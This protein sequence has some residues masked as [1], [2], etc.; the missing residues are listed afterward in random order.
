[1]VGSASKVLRCFLLSQAGVQRKKVRSVAPSLTC[2][3]RHRGKVV[4][5][6]INFYSKTN[7][8][9]AYQEMLAAG[10][11]RGLYFYWEQ[12]LGLSRVNHTD[13]PASP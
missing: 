13:C 12:N 9:A 5:V 2:T 6:G 7:T 8:E 3:Y 10:K 1:M 11:A 4:F